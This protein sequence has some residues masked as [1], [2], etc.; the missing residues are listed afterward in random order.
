MINYIKFFLQKLKSSK[1]KIVGKCKMC[2]NCCRNITFMNGKQYIETEQQFEALKN[3]DKRYNIFEICGKNENGALLFKCLY[4]GDDNKCKK[5]WLRSLY[6]RNYPR[7][8]QKFLRNGGVLL[9]GCGYKI[10]KTKE[11][12]EFLE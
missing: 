11:F 9:D 1:Y 3:F 12:K 8:S 5:Y 2:G 6:C 7:P 4:L 10:T